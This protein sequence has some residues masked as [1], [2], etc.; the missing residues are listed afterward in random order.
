[1]SVEEARRAAVREAEA[2]RR[3]IEPWQLEMAEAVPSDLVAD[4]V[5]DQRKGISAPSS[6]TPSRDVRGAGWVEPRSL[7]P[8]PHSE[9]IDRIV[10]AQIGGPNDTSKL[11]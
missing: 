3:G 5:G 6:V 4:I 9:L 1:M 2:R 11:K 7:G 10:E 8:M